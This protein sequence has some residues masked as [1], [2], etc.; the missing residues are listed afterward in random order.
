MNSY[1]QTLYTSIIRITA[2]ALMVAAVFVSMYQSSRSP[3][4]S[5]LMF[6]AWFFGISVPIWTGAFWLTRRVREWFP[7]EQQ[8]LVDLPRLGRGLVSWRVAEAEPATSPAQ[9]RR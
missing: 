5:E 4:S 6:C 2:N 1:R 8:S 7:A 3:E 9:A